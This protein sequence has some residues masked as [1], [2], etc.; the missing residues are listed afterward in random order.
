MEAIKEDSYSFIGE[1]AARAAMGLSLCL[2][3]S[4]K[5]VYN[6]FNNNLCTHIST[7]YQISDI[8]LQ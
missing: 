4:K 8:R 6:K 2:I 5:V 1:S 7:N 3:K